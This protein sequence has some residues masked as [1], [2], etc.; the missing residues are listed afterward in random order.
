[1]TQMTLPADTKL[2]ILTT[3]AKGHE[4]QAQGL[5][6][7][8]GLEPQIK[9]IALPAP[10]RWLAPWGP[11]PKRDDLQAPWPDMVIATGRQAIP[12]A[13]M[14]KKRSGGKTFVVILQNPRVPTKWFD[15]FW[16]PVH[17]RLEGRNVHSTLTAPSLVTPEKLSAAAQKWGPTMANLP[18]PR[19]AVLIGGANKLYDFTPDT[20]AALGDQLAFLARTSGA[21]LMITTSRRTGEAQTAALKQAFADTNAYFWDGTG[22]N[23]YLGMLGLADAILVTGE[24][25]NMV[26]E[27]TTTGKPVHVIELTPRKKGGTTK[28]RRFLDA[29]YAKG[30]ARP[31]QGQLEQWSY[32]PL[33]PTQEI[34]EHIVTAFHTR[35]TL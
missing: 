26:G 9:R 18:T 27:A 11:A 25:T 35:H 1:M 22:D 2:W 20:A 12:H 30:V 4:I 29:L 21:G 7:C 3:H 8:L 28:F 19:V 15:F 14:I 6:Q 34:A 16:A 5:A 31:F 24:S 10:W 23:P 32:E 33:A 13:R 17:D